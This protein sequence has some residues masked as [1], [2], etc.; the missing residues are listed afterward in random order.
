MAGVSTE[1][2]SWQPE[3]MS[4][5]LT[6]MERAVPALRRYA[7]A[8]LRDADGA[9]DLVQSTLERALSRRRLWRRDGSLRAWLYTILRNIHRNELR[10]RARRPTL[11]AVDLDEI[12]PGRPGDQIDR[13]YLGEVLGALDRLSQDHREVLLLAGVEELSYREIAAVVGVPIGTV[14]SRL[15]R[16]RDALAGHLEGDEATRL[17]RVK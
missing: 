4:D 11:V 13:V 10:A 9:D 15:S 14:M 6:E 12:G 16:A 17:R 7:R 1:E 5:F 2:R 3:E 8:L